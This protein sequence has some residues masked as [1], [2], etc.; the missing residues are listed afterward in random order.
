[1]ADVADRDP[2]KYLASPGGKPATIYVKIH[3]PEG[4]VREVI[5]ERR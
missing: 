3:G 4:Q 5:L 2:D 1:M